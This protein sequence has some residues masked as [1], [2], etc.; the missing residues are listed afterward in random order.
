MKKAN[1]LILVLALILS[2]VSSCKK[3]DDD[4][5]NNNNN[6]TNNPLS[7]ALGGSPTIP[8][9]AAGA[10]YAVNNYVISD[11]G[12]GDMD[13]TELGTAYAWFES[14]ATT[15]NAGTVSCNTSE[16]ENEF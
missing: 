4:D 11:D 6:N 10:L 7:Q 13:T 9:D 16:L 5:N 14:Y 2:T 12:F 8:S 3:D 1:L 15:T